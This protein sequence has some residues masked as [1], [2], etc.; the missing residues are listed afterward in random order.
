M[1]CGKHHRAVTLLADVVILLGVAVSGA[2]AGRAVGMAP[3]VAYL[4][5]GVL[6]GPGVLGLVDR[7]H[8]PE[9]PAEP[10]VALLLFG[11]GL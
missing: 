2:L 3:T 7:S 6:A 4:L 8:A 11:V 9:Q 1:V 5:A 10:G